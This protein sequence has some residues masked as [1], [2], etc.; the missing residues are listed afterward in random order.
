[1]VGAINF[2]FEMIW[3]DR[4]NVWNPGVILIKVKVRLF[5]SMYEVISNQST[6]QI[7]T[8]RPTNLPAEVLRRKS[9]YSQNPKP[10]FSKYCLWNYWFYRVREPEIPEILI[11]T[12]GG[13]GVAPKDG[14]VWP[15]HWI[16]A[17]QSFLGG[18]SA[19][20]AS[21]SAQATSARNTNVDSCLLIGS[22]LIGVY[23]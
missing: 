11:I 4:K 5:R 15:L 7:H 2:A 13:M 16:M 19:G 23:W 1:M 18:P 17:L 14:G 22:L 6:T 20:S 9:D 21:S 8:N 10:R 12:V 3:T